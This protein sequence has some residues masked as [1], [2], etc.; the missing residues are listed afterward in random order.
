MT[1]ANVITRQAVQHLNNTVR[2]NPWRWC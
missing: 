2:H 1:G